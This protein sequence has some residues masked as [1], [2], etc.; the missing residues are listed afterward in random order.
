MLIKHLACILIFINTF[1]YLF[2]DAVGNCIADL[3]QEIAKKGNQSPRR[4]KVSNLITV[5]LQ[6]RFKVLISFC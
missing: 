6:I 5:K 2:L 3:A 4:E 1:I